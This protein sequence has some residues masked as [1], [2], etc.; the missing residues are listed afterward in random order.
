MKLAENI[1]GI[2]HIGIPTA[3]VEESVH[4][5]EDLGF[6]EV[7]RE[8][9]LRGPVVFMQLK[10]LVIEFYVPEACAGRAG[11]VDHF[12]LDVQDIEA[13][14]AEA[15]K[16]GYHLLDAEIVSRPFWENGMRFFNIEG[17]NAEKIE[18]SQKL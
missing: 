13:A 7:L 15:K 10:S 14:F 18:F 16:N 3:S 8:K 9:G 12:A 4:F 11:A 1:T 2:Q 17:P 6:V 5:Y